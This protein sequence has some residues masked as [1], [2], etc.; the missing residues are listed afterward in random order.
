MKL[1]ADGPTSEEIEVL[2]VD[3]YTFNP[4]LYKK[5]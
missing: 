1:Y 3:G 4:T 5:F 2:K